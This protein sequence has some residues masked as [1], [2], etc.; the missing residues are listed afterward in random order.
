[1]FGEADFLEACAEL[2]T[3]IVTGWELF[4]ETNDIKIYRLRNEVNET[5]D[6][7]EID[8]CHITDC[9]KMFIFTNKLDLRCRA[10]FVIMCVVLF[11]WIC[12]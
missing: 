9:P 3:P 11:S 7:L 2:D 12:L 6:C 1:M 8:R 10:P 4:A 5:K